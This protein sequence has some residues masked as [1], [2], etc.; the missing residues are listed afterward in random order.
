M[1][2]DPQIQRLEIENYINENFKHHP[3]LN[4]QGNLKYLAECMRRA[5]LRW[6]VLLCIDVEAWEKDN[7]KVTEIGIALYNP[8]GQEYALVPNI[9]QV[10]IRIEE[11]LRLRNGRYV[12]DHADYSNSGVS[13]TML[14]EDAVLYLQ[15]LVDNYINHP[16]LSAQGASLVGHNIRGD[17]AW[18][19]KLGVDF[20][21]NL[22]FIDT[23]KLFALSNGKQ[24][25]SLV[26]GL[27]RVQI[28]HAY[29]HNAGNDAYYTLLL[30]MKLC[31]PNARRFYNLDFLVTKEFIFPEIRGKKSRKKK[32]PNRAKL[33][34][35]NIDE[36]IIDI[37]RN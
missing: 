17:I 10:H 36:L 25:A 11:S 23:E 19:D 9:K 12:P 29:L 26:N 16:P 6:H 30:A 18:L 35:G 37:T 3:F 31:D 28:P 7:E 22:N 5:Y 32:D 21:E 24:G 13:Y 33:L 8:I 1:S 4:N 34:E 15:A 20:H 27:E 14:E 2:Y